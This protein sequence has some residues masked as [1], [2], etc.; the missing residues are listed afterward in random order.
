MTALAPVTL[1][2]ERPVNSLARRSNS[3]VEGVAGRFSDHGSR[4]FVAA[5]EPFRCD[6]GVIRSPVVNQP[7]G[8]RKM[9]AR[10]RA[11]ITS[12]CQEVRP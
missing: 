5:F 3:S 1:K 9:N 2:S 6:A 10:I 12:Y 4:S 8:V 7:S 11:H